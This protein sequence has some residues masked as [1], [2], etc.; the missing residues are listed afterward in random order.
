MSFLPTENKYLQLGRRVRSSAYL[1]ERLSRKGGR[2]GGRVKA[3]ILQLLKDKARGNVIAVVPRPLGPRTFPSCPIS[4]V[5]EIHEVFCVNTGVRA[6]S[7][8]IT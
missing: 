3:F 1:M 5:A 2:G 8:W 6:S 7:S 4:P